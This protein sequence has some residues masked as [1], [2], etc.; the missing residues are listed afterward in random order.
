MPTYPSDYVQPPLQLRRGTLAKVLDYYSAEGELTYSTDTR[1]VFVGDGITLGGLELLTTSTTATNAVAGGIKVGTGLNITADG[2]LNLNTATTSTYGGV[3]AGSG[4]SIDQYGVLTV[5]G[6]G[7]G[8]DFSTVTNQK[9]FTT[10]SVIF[11]QVDANTGS[12]GA[13]LF[14]G[15][16]IADNAYLDGE[17]R[18]GQD[19]TDPG[20]ITGSSGLTGGL[21]L[22]SRGG[23]FEGGRIVLTNSDNGDGEV[24]LG[25]WNGT[26]LNSVMNISTTSGVIVNSP[27]NLFVSGYINS[28]TFVQPTAG[29]K[30]NLL[31]GTTSTPSGTNNIVLGVEAGKN[32]STGSYPYLKDGNIAIGYRA[33]ASWGFI[34]ETI[35]EYNIAIGYEAGDGVVKNNGI[36]IG[37]RAGAGVT[38][39]QSATIIGPGPGSGSL[40]NG[41]SIGSFHTERIRITTT[42][43]YI[44]ALRSSTSTMVAYYNSSTKE[45]SYGPAPVSGG[46]NAQSDQALYTTSSV[47]FNNVTVTN[48]A[49]ADTLKANTITHN[50]GGGI[51]IPTNINVNQVVVGDGSNTAVIYSK[52]VNNLL[53]M[54]NDSTGIGGRV[55]V[56]VGESSGVNIGNH[57]KTDILQIN[58]STGVSVAG[59][60]LDANTATFGNVTVSNSVYSQDYRGSSGNPNTI[61]FGD[62]TAPAILYANGVNNL[63]LSANGST[64]MGAKLTLT[65]GETGSVQLG[66]FNNNNIMEISTSSIQIST[67]PLTANTAT[68]NGNLTVQS[69]FT[70]NADTTFNGFIDFNNTASVKNIVRDYA[71]GFLTIGEKN[72]PFYTV[73]ANTV[74]TDAIEIRNTAPLYLRGSTDIEGTLQVGTGSADGNI[75]AKGTQNLVLSGNGSTG[76]GA[77]ISLGSGEGDTGIVRLGHFNNNAI[78]TVST[79]S[80]VIVGTNIPFFAQ[81][82]AQFNGGLNVTTV[83]TFS[84]TIN[85]INNNKIIT[86]GTT[87]ASPVEIWNSSGT[88]ADHS[89]IRFFRQR[90]S[91]APQ[92]ANI[93]GALQ[94]DGWQT[95]NGYASTTSTNRRFPGI[96]WQALGNFNA[97]NAGTQVRFQNRVSYN[98]N[99]PFPYNVTNANTTDT[100]VVEQ[101]FMNTALTVLKGSQ[102]QLYDPFQG[103][104]PSSSLLVSPFHNS[105]FGTQRFSASRTS[106]GSNINIALSTAYTTST[107][108]LAG[109]QSSMAIRAR[110]DNIKWWD[111][112]VST[113]NTST[114]GEVNWFA[115]S[116]TTSS[117][118]FGASVVKG[119]NLSLNAL[120]YQR[121][122]YSVTRGTITTSTTALW[123]T[124]TQAGDVLGTISF[125]GGLESQS[126]GAGQDGNVDGIIIR[127]YAVNNWQGQNTSTTTSV[128]YSSNET[129]LRIEHAN[130]TTIGGVAIPALAGGAGLKQQYGLLAEFGKTTSTFNTVIN[131][132]ND[133]LIKDTL[134]TA[135]KLTGIS[136][137]ATQVVGSFAA[138]AYDAAKF[139]VKIVDG[140]S[141]H[142]VEI[143]VITDGTD[144][145][146]VEYG[147]NTSDGVL[148]TFDTNL[149]SGVVELRFTPTT[150]TAMTIAT[151]ITALPKL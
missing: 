95:T 45:L 40:N 80:G 77:K 21:I 122:T 63:Q 4:L 28:G 49:T 68:F 150:A 47:T 112:G 115:E 33:M 52:N 145:W 56:L 96:D 59:Y 62:A 79:Q 85:V 117:W 106:A 118:I 50:G 123:N 147:I 146:K 70:A 2:V 72:W 44:N 22:T 97:N 141:I 142:F 73:F 5:T 61:L 86:T 66:H 71:D 26:T 17:L 91:A 100:T 51:N 125:Q 130:T 84:N 9:L 137:T 74:T 135:N 34:G 24:R 124:S 37:Y 92:S 19:Q 67:V 83:S 69:S 93:L 13:G 46:G 138:A 58:T 133:V 23:G 64:G 143:S 148:G 99:N 65:T 75:F 14:S 41:L 128:T 20:L 55:S 76:M 1:Q 109:A 98:A 88:A 90:G 126:I 8:G 110:T 30:Y 35:P 10:S 38:D 6:G 27:Y 107:N 127:A 140:T 12:F 113:L 11:A 54:P 94:I 82:T 116:A 111:L 48:T 81:G 144:I 103:W 78:M 131:N 25:L 42:A 120:R 39:C 29:S 101:L 43:T 108:E 104:D 31:I 121:G 16:I 87:Y 36:F 3:I 57:H 15:N 132:K 149:N 151:A 114:A 102:F 136:T 105:V 7:G 18:V 134:Y 53:L 119:V 129:A 139:A 60:P 32:Q 89:A